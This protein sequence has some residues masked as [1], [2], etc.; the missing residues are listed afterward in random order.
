LSS[1]RN[2][3]ITRNNPDSGFESDSD[4]GLDL[5]EEDN[6]FVTIPD[7]IICEVDDDDSGDEYECQATDGE[8]AIGDDTYGKLV[9]GLIWDFKEVASGDMPFMNNKTLYEGE[10]KLRPGIGDSWSTPFESFQAM[11]CNRGFVALLAQ[12]SN[13]YAKNHLLGVDNP[14]KKVSGLPWKDISTEEMYRFLGIMLKISL[15]PID[16]GGYSAYFRKDDMQIEYSRHLPLQR[17]QDTAG[18]AHKYMTEGRFK[19]IRVAFH[20][21]DKQMASGGGDKCYQ[22]RR[23]INRINMSSKTCFVAGRDMAFDEGGV[24]CRSRFCPVR[25]YNASKPQ[26]FRV[27]FFILACSK[28]YAIL[29][30]DVYQGRNATNVGIKPYLHDLPTTQKATM[31]AVI[32]ALGVEERGA[33]HVSIDNRYQCPELAV[34][35]MTKANV[36]STGTVRK[37]R[38]G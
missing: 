14:T 25:Q 34:L 15:L 35:L 5:D 26:K 16:G 2:S 32:S 33:R 11:G 17:I 3:R 21:E 29:H 28:S 18:F 36:Y 24:G 27:D 30:L 8:S 9:S 4:D 20:P 37:N 38:K 6:A 7:N 12:H 1:G 10:T 22:L 23:A 13:D 19:Q 31:N